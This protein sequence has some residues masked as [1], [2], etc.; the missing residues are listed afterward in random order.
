MKRIRSTDTPIRS[1]DE[2]CALVRDMA[3]EVE[4]RKAAKAA[5]KRKIAALR[6]KDAAAE[7]ASKL[8]LAGMR[9]LVEDWAKGHP[10]LMVGGAY[11]VA[12]A[13]KFGYRMMP[14][15]TLLLDGFTDEKVAAALKFAG[16]GDCVRED[17]SL[18]RLV[19][20]SR[21]NMAGPLGLSSQFLASVGLRVAQGDRAFY[22][23]TWTRKPAPVNKEKK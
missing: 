15:V 4:A 11:G 18:D 10:G 6:E 16:R 23:D 7:V 12:G 5:A 14:R 20:L 22:V 1:E 9:A 17:G 8:R 21:A 2:V 19:I 3:A 13:G